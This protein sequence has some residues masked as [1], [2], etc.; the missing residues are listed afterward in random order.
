[1]GSPALPQ[2]ACTAADE[3]KQDLGCSLGAR[4]LF[5]ARMRAASPAPSKGLP[6][7]EAGM[8]VRIL[9]VIVTAAAVGGCS[10]L[11]I[12]AHFCLHRAI[13]FMAR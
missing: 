1:M 4:Q 3:C 7:Q 6:Y 2:I 11:F 10:L 5:M 8:L 13:A 12:L 9:I